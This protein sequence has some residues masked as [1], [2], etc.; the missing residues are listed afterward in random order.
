[1]G[2]VTKI[3]GEFARALE[4]ELGKAVVGQAELLEETTA[5]LLTGGHVL[6]EGVP[7]TAKTLLVRALGHALDLSWGR[8]QFTPDLM[9]ADVTGS[10]VYRPEKAE[11]EFRPG[12]VFVNLLLAD[13]INRAP[14]KTQA[15]LLEAMEEGAVTIDGERHELPRPFVVFATQNPIEHEGTYPLP[16]AQLDRFMFKSVVDLPGRDEEI[17]IL[18]RHRDGFDPRDLDAAGIRAVTSPER[19][20]SGMAAAVREAVEVEDAVLGYT[21]DLVRQTRDWSGIAIGAG[22]RAAVHLMRGARAL[23]AMQGRDFV[24]PDDVKRLSVPVLRHRIMLEAEREMEGVTPDEVIRD[25]VGSLAVPR[26]RE[27][28]G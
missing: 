13:E 16:E 3:I 15:A 18:R 2:D 17:E 5:A 9:P 7:G 8:I 22:P 12:P 27:D 24:L 4:S 25:L 6:L 14:A 23:A 1:M 21:A 19:A 20:L 26:T 10:T 11:F 28:E